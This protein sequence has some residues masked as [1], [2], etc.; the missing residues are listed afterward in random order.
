MSSKKKSSEKDIHNLRQLLRENILSASSINQ[1]QLSKHGQNKNKSNQKYFSFSMLKY[2][3]KRLINFKGISIP[4][5]ALG[6][7]SLDYSKTFGPENISRIKKSSKV[8]IFNS[9]TIITKNKNNIEELIKDDENLVEFKNIYILK[10]AQYSNNFSKFHLNKDYISDARKRDFEDLYGKISK[11]L[12]IQ[13]QILLND[14][15]NISQTQEN[16][17]IFVQ[18]YTNNTPSNKEKN[19]FHY[20]KKSNNN[21]NNRKKILG[22]CSDFSYYVIK[23]IN[24]LFKEIKEYK[25]ECIK[26]L[27]KNYEYELKINTLMKELDDIKNY[28]NKYNINKKIFLEKEK[29]N[30]IKIMKDKYIRKE[31]E[32]IVSMY[33]LQDEIHSLIQLLDKNKNYYNKYKEV[34]KE[35][36]NNKKNN[37]LLRIKFNKELNEK[38]LQFA[39]EKDKREELVSQLEELNDT[40]KELKEQKEQ[41]K[42]Q[43]IEITAQILK[44]KIIIDEKNENLM[45]MSEEL[46]YFMREY[47]REKYNHQNTL[48]VLRSLE[49]RIYNEEKERKN[50][51]K[52]ISNSEESD[53][54]NEI[55]SSVQ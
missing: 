30:S 14:I 25:N 43:E 24:I 47:N 1:I 2:K 21:L 34:E 41:Q 5:P 29:E 38:N 31:N 17:D 27:K 18:T 46:E 40:I 48:A 16:N 13:S 26:L 12:E 15:D 45:M 6:K 28:L 9:K 37:D 23:F 7:A 36:D 44:M 51:I 20:D 54:N 3:P 19:N 55:N 33:K 52:N 39:L 8:N 11:S 53:K 50:I 42:R 49:N 35:I 10:Y 4:L 22:I 32:Y